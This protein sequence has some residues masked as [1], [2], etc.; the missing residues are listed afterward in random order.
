MTINKIIITVGLLGVTT[1]LGINAIY[2]PKVQTDTNVD[3]L[4]FSAVEEKT[5]ATEIKVAEIDTKV[6]EVANVQIE[7]AK[8]IEEVKTQVQQVKTVIV[9]APQVQSVMEKPIAPTITYKEVFAKYK[10]LVSTG[11]TNAGMAQNCYKHNVINVCTVITTTEPGTTYTKTKTDY[12]LSIKW[13]Y[14]TETYTD[15]LNGATYNST[16]VLD[17]LNNLNLS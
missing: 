17:I 15:L 7:Q 1:A 5:K 6:Q 2:T 3:R 13:S 16:E 11:K 14:G 9:Q 8:Q 12:T 10:E 4:E